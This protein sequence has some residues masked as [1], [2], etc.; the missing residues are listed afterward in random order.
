[1]NKL[2]ICV[3][4]ESTLQKVDECAQEYDTKLKQWIASQTEYLNGKNAKKHLLCNLL[5]LHAY[6]SASEEG[7]CDRLHQEL[8]LTSQSDCL[9]RISAAPQ[10]VPTPLPHTLPPTFQIIGDNV[11]LRQKPTH[12]T[13]DRRGKDHH[14]FHMVAVK[15]RAVSGDISDTQP[16]AMVKDLELHTFLPTIEDCIKLKHEFVILCARVL[17]ERL[18]AFKHLRECVPTHVPHKF[19][20]EMSLKSEIVCISNLHPQMH[21]YCSLL[22]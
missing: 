5:T 19:S 2:Q 8:P 14:W 13:L 7:A 17:T 15:D 10:G 9:D 20:R 18:A 3:S 6:C 22:C 1:M 16:S 21:H 4:A 11:D 12:Q